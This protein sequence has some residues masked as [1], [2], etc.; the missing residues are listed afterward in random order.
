[1]MIFN[2]KYQVME[3]K[4]YIGMG[5]QFHQLVRESITEMI[6]EGN[7]VN[8]TSKF[9]DKQSDEESWDEYKSKT[10]WNDLNIGVPLLFNFYHGLELLL[11]GILQEEGV[12][13]KPT[14][15][16]NELF[17]EISNDMNLPDSLI[18]PIKKYI[19]TTNQFQEVFRMNNS[20]PNQYHLLLRYPENKNKTHI[21]S[22]IRGQEKIGLNNFIELKEDI[23][24]IKL[25]MVNWVVNK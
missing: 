19:D 22:K 23:D 3:R 17:S 25:E 10:R 1:M 2:K 11:K 5:Y 24:K 14:H 18:S 16:L 21:F 9:D 4:N 15:K 7:K 20:S 12:S 13:L 6:K 8:I